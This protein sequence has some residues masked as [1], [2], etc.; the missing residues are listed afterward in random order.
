MPSNKRYE[1]IGTEEPLKQSPPY[2]TPH[3]NAKSGQFQMIGDGVR[4]SERSIQS[5][6]AN[7]REGSREI[8]GDK[9]PLSRTPVKGWGNAAYLQMSDRAHEQS[10]TAAGGGGRSGRKRK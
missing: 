10:K 9:A 4:M 6:S 5:P 7:P 8:L 1:I 3:E 2:P